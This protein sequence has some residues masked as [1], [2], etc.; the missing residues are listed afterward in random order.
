MPDYLKKAKE[1]SNNLLK[2][3]GFEAEAIIVEKDGIV[4]INIAADD[5][6]LL[7]GK[8]G[9]GLTA[10]E[11]IIR[12]LLN[13]EMEDHR[14][15]VLDIAGYR[16]KKSE[17][18]KKFAHDKAFMV[19][20]TGIEEVMPPMSSYERRIIHLTCANI[21]DIETESVGEGRE[22]RVVIKPKKTTK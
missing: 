10:L 6:G 7:I 21:A 2:K 8:G 20:S 4:Y 14:N 13:A 1:H 15:V 5:P 22:R 9:E 12:L 16:N 17:N 3:L 18:V 11:H 19:L